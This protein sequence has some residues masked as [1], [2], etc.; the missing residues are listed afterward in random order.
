MDENTGYVTSEKA[1]EQELAV[2]NNAKEIN[3]EVIN[4]VRQG[5]DLDKAITHA[6]KYII[7]KYYPSPP[8]SPGRDET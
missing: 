8:P 7:P 4:L 6:T 3:A 1:T 2:L 5:M